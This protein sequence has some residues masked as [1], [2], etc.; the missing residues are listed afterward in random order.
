MG[1][2]HD[3]GGV[4]EGKRDV[5]VD[6][7]ETKILESRK[8]PSEETGPTWEIVSATTA[9]A[10]S[11]AFSPCPHLS[12]YLQFISTTLILSPFLIDRH[13]AL[14]SAIFFNLRKL[15]RHHIVFHSTVYR[16]DISPAFPSPS[17]LPS[18]RLH[19]IRT[20]D[21]SISPHPLDKISPRETSY[22]QPNTR[23]AT[24]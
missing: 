19:K 13:S 4:V 16:I 8:T 5:V 24:I 10:T 3:H 17:L 12:V 20:H 11:I 21:P 22:Q 6:K 18:F 2:R 14:L 1:T 7:E 9:S 15:H 23:A